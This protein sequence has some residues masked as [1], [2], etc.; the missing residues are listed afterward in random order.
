MNKEK[1]RVGWIGT[2]VMGKSMCV[3]LLRAG[4]NCSVYNRTKEKAS[5]LIALGAV[6]QNSPREI[7][8]SSD[9]IFTI[10]SYPKDVKEVYFGKDGVL[11]GAKAGAMLVDMSTSEPSLAVEIYDRAQELGIFSIDAPVSGGDIGARNATLSIMIGGDIEI[12]EKLNPLFS[13]L[14]KTIVHQ[15]PAGAGQHC[16]M[17]NQIA[18]ATNMIGVCESLLYAYKAGLDLET[19]LA[20]ISGGGAGSWSIS[21]LAPRI[22]AGNFD[23]GFFVEHFVKDMGIALRE[24]ERMDL[25]LPGL[26]LAKSL[27]DELVKQ[28]GA[29]KGTQALQ[30]VIAKLSD[31]DWSQL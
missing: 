22:V 10:V 25:K 8:Q 6:W 16:K 9:V 21:N 31:V 24:A 7:A 13:L 28:G 1:I 17:C 11:T 5:E 18:I 20:S 4:F 27:Y 23:P 15:G 12:V 29:K 30:L 19:V 3:N 26:E 2:G 14:G